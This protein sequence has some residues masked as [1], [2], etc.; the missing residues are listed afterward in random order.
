MLT[1]S[2]SMDQPSLFGTVKK[3]HN[4][5]SNNKTYAK[6]RILEL[7]AHTSSTSL[8]FY[9]V[10]D[11]VLVFV[12][13]WRKTIHWLFTDYSLFKN[14][15]EYSDFAHKYIYASIWLYIINKF[16][17]F[18]SSCATFFLILTFDFVT[19]FESFVFYSSFIP[20]IQNEFSVLYLVCLISNR[21][22]N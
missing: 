8:L 4:I 10:Y 17:P 11:L 1:S 18:L 22:F 3:L 13:I 15:S 12:L 6:R 16:Y 21:F 2:K 7:Q 19:Y 9:R 20:L 5:I 14:I